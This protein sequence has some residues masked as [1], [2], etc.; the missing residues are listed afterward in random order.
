M[1]VKKRYTRTVYYFCVSSLQ[2]ETSGIPV[3]NGSTSNGASGGFGA[4]VN[5]TS[6]FRSITDSCPSSCSSLKTSVTVLIENSDPII[7][8]GS[9]GFLV[10]DLARTAYSKSV[11]TPFTLVHHKNGLNLQLAETLHNGE[12]HLRAVTAPDTS[13]IWL[14]RVNEVG[15]ISR[16]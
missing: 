4:R 9:S 5:K 14:W 13:E 6:G 12:F 2:D 7:M 8:K 16:R 10:S 15:R 3:N 1:R 11:P